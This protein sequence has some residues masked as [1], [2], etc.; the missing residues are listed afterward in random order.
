MYPSVTI[1]PEVVLNMLGALCGVF[2]GIG[3][4]VLFLSLVFSAVFVGCITDSHGML[5][6]VNFTT[7]K[8]RRFTFNSLASYLSFIL[9]VLT[10]VFTVNYL[11]EK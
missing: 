5:S 8:A 1:F 7:I 3:S 4:S 9:K 10:R 11:G 6:L 2:V